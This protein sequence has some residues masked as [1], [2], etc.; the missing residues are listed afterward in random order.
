MTAVVVV[1]PPIDD[2][3]RGT[4]TTN[5][6]KTTTTGKENNKK[7]NRGGSAMV[8]TS[9]DT[10]F[11]SD[12]QRMVP[13]RNSKWTHSSPPKGPDLRECTTIEDLVATTCTNLRVMSPR[14]ISAFWTI[15]S[16]LVQNQSGR[17]QRTNDNHGQGQIKKQLNMILVNTLENIGGYNCR[18]FTTTALGMAK[19]VKQVDRC[20]GGRKSQANSLNQILHNLFIGKDSQKKHLIFNKIAIS[21]IPIIHEFEP[22]EL[23]NYIYAYGLVEFVPNNIKGELTLF[24]VLAREAI[25]KLRRFSS[26]NLSNM[27]WAYAKVGASNSSLFEAAGITIVAMNDLVD[28]WPQALSN[29]LWAYASAGEPHPR[30]FKRVADHILSLRDLNGFKP[31]EISN[32]FWAYATADEKHP[33]LFRRVA[34]HI[35]SLRDLSGFNSQD[36]SN[37]VWAYATAGDSNP[38]LFER[39]ADHILSLK[40]LSGFTSQ[41]LSNIMWAYATAGQSHT[42]LFQKLADVAIAKREEFNSQSV[43]NFLWAYATIG[44]TDQ[45][46]F[47]SFA[48]TVKS[49]MGECNSQNLANIG[50]AYAVANVSVPSLFDSDF[51]SACLA[52][53]NDFSEEDLRQLHQWQLW[54]EEL[55]SDV[56]LPLTFRDQCQKVMTSALTQLSNLQADVMFELFS[57]GLRPEEEYLLTH[58]GYRLDALVEV[59]GTKVGIEV[60]GPSHFFGGKATGKTLLKRRQVTSLDEITVVSVP[61]WDW[62]KLG[63]DHEKKQEYLRTLLS[64]G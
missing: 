44:Q 49:K 51:I 27:L 25:F 2:D 57:I 16:K 9:E 56:R 55:K 39:V 21:S 28:F 14:D 5:R 4:R 15:L 24:D 41:A 20:V 11:S 58:T 42:L 26:Q 30:L 64:F 3:D 10:T 29:I 61:Y 38:R 50:W 33:Q 59:K 1:V 54:Q 36:V 32:I 62:N 34:E 43:A 40:D 48:P 7:V 46:L 35:V 23:S 19:I 47:L 13:P 53:E 52:K 60:D 45:R 63:K 18:D 22:R 37:I 8:V 31:Q 6:T 17:P 12:E